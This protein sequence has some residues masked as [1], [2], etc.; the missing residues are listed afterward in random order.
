MDAKAETFR[1]CA[2][3]DPAPPPFKEPAVSP[4]DPHVPVREPDRR[5]FQ[6]SAEKEQNSK[7]REGIKAEDQNKLE[8]L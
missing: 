4:E 8:D 5:H 7:I 2:P 1:L 3:A 6:L